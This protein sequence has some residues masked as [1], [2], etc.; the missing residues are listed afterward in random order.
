MICEHL[1]IKG[2]KSVNIRLLRK[3]LWC[4]TFF[5]AVTILVLVRNSIDE[6]P[7]SLKSLSHHR[8][9]RGNVVSMKRWLHGFVDS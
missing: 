4:V 1:Q 6:T 5:S 8:F 2:N 9:N 7:V 3:I